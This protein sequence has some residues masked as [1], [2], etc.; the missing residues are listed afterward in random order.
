M[1]VNQDLHPSR[2]AEG[3]QRAT[4]PKTVTA[5]AKPVKD[6]DK[7]KTTLM[8]LHAVAVDRTGNPWDV[9][10]DEMSPFP[11]RR[12][13]T[14]RRPAVGSRRA[15]HQNLKDNIT[16]NGG[17]VPHGVIEGLSNHGQI[18]P[19]PLLGNRSERLLRRSH[20]VRCQ[21]RRAP[22]K[23]L[24]IFKGSEACE[25]PAGGDNWSFTCGP[26]PTKGRLGGLPKPQGL[27]P[28]ACAYI[29]KSSQAT[30]IVVSHKLT[31]LVGKRNRDVTSEDLGRG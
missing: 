19:M 22:D 31:I 9:D 11:R 14:R 23:D 30:A 10:N 25:F 2:L 12:C 3:V 28:K 29:E 16:H 18:S 15:F 21:G 17:Y 6:L 26:P 20:P 13:G 4:R 24:F 1:P 8:G 7:N 5:Y 27:A